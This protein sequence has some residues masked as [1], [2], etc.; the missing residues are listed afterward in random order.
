MHKNYTESLLETVLSMVLKYMMY[1]SFL[2][3]YAYAF[4]FSFSLKVWLVRAISGF[5]R[6][7]PHRTV[8]TIVIPSMKQ[9]AGIEIFMR[10]PLKLQ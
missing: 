7:H 6:S 1:N 8:P 3:F 5:Y 2:P 10:K 4:L 9:T